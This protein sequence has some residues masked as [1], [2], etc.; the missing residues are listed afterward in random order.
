MSHTLQLLPRDPVIAR[1]GR[2][3]GDAGVTRQHVL[4]WLL[5]GTLAG[6]VRTLLGRKAGQ[7]FDADTI[8]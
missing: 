5:P 3:F 2:P 7:S 1:D 8:E 4:P 6:A